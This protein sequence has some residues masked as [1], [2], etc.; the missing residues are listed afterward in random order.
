MH[1]EDEQTDP[2]AAKI[3]IDIS[4]VGWLCGRI[5]LDAC[6]SNLLASIT[7]DTLSAHTIPTIINA[8]W[9]HVY[10][11]SDAGHKW[12][13]FGRDNGGTALCWGSGD[14]AFANCLS[15]PQGQSPVGVP[16]YAGITY[17]VDGVCHQAANRILYPVGSGGLIVAQAKGYGL[18]AFLYGTY[19]RGTKVPWPQ[20]SQCASLYLSAGG[21]PSGGPTVAQND[22][23]SARL[24]HGIRKIYADPATDESTIA[25][26]ELEA[27]AREQLGEGYDR[28]KIAAVAEYQ[29]QWREKQQDFT[30]RLKQ[31]YLSPEG[32]RLILRQVVAETAERC[33]AVLGSE[34]F[35]RLFGVPAKDAADLLTRPVA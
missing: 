9:D 1:I 13:C 31:G 10:V 26:R 21:A 11:I 32:Y 16:I 12:G 2:N 17:A 7:V 20:L 22:S 14:A 19:G 24:A 33:E 8:G 35:E 27:L 34:D 5:R 18:S 30:E 4:P 6:S 3:I 29:R 23:K 25:L 28:Q 15:T